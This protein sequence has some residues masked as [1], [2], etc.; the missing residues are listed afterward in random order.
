[1]IFSIIVSA[2][3]G[4]TCLMFKIFSWNLY[5]IILEYAEQK[6]SLNGTVHT[7]S[8]ETPAIAMKKKWFCL[9]FF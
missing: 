5:M 8:K 9:C 6:S 3:L 4:G 1:M 2:M 7:V